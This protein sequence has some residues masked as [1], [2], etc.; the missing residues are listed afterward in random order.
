MFLGMKTNGRLRL[1]IEGETLN[2]T[3]HSKLPGIEIDSKLMFSKHIETL[4]H[5]VNKITVFSRL[6]NVI[7]T[8]QAQAIY[9]AVILSNFNYYPLIWMFCNKGANKQIDRTH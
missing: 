7:S 4:C 1:D 2:A 8:Q 3:D 6:N 9:N 5:K